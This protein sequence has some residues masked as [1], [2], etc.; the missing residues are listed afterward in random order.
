MSTPTDPAERRRLVIRTA[1]RS[2]A[3]SIALLLV[4]CVVPVPGRSGV[5]A[6][7]GLVAGLAFFLAVVA[8]QLHTIINAR[9]PLVRAVELVALALPLLLVVFAYTYLSISE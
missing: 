8:K 5:G 2:L 6:L 7:I 1:L 9:N 3:L 4:Y